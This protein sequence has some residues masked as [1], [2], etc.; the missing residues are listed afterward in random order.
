M[1]AKLYRMAIGYPPSVPKDWKGRLPLGTA[2]RQN[3]LV[4]LIFSNQN[5][6]ND[7]KTL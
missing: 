5:R 3:F 7:R 4:T 1:I 6:P 2:R